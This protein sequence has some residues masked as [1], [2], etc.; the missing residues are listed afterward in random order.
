[1]E[2]FVLLLALALLA[3]AGL[4]IAVWRLLDLIACERARSVRARDRADQWRNAYGV[5]HRRHLDLQ[6]RY[7]AALLGRELTPAAR[8]LYTDLESR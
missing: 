3:V 5:L 1:M 4:A 7:G 2:I 8:T 6:A